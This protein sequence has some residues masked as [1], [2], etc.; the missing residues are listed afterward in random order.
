MMSSRVQRAGRPL[1]TP[2]VA[3][4]LVA[5]AML[6]SLRL[7]ARAG[8]RALLPRPRARAFVPAVGGQKV[9]TLDVEQK[10]HPPTDRS[11]ANALS[12][13]RCWPFG[14]EPVRHEEFL[15]VFA[16]E[17]DPSRAH[18]ALARRC[19]EGL[20]APHGFATFDAGS[21]SRPTNDMTE[22]RFHNPKN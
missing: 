16:G 9:A 3:P 21:H 5:G 13:V 11:A 4:A 15:S 22:N 14:I 12:Q 1:R 20:Q 8:R 10:A 19:A 2:G 17:R 7:G 6:I 18:V